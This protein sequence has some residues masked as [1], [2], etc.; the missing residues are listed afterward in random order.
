MR[1][2]F[3]I[4]LA[5]LS[6]PGCI[7]VSGHVTPQGQDQ[8]RVVFAVPLDRPYTF[9]QPDPHQRLTGQVG[10]LRAQVVTVHDGDT[11]TVLI[12]NQQEKLSL[13]GI[14]APELDQTPWGTQSRQ[15]LKDIVEG[16]MV[17]LETDIAFRD[18][19]RR[20]LAYVYLGD[21]LVNLELVRQGYAVLNTVPP[22][23]AHV[24][25]Y[26][27]AQTEAREAGRGVWSADRPPELQPDCFR[28]QQARNC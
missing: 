19:Y 24:D 15:A 14:D 11:I 22:N 28:H 2:V 26:Q 8:S 7:G 17:R 1:P 5:V 20:L 18:Q 13:A 16:K 6:V 10:F 4:P 23:V 21:M 25:E 9:R 3:L 12:D 27:K